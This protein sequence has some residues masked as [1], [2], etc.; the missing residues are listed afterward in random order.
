MEFNFFF[1][2]SKVL[3]TF[4]LVQLIALAYDRFRL[5]ISANY[6]FT[7]DDDRTNGNKKM[8]PTFK[9]L[10]Y[11]FLIHFYGLPRTSLLILRV[12]ISSTKKKK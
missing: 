10:M 1:S 8:I 9:F 6:A 7:L 2:I 4:W 3:K 11:R 5:L 12:I